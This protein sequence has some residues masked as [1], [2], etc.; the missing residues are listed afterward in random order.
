MACYSPLKA[1]KLVN[2]KTQSGKSVIVFSRKGLSHDAYVEMELPCGQCIGCRIDKSRQWAL[3]SVHEASLYGDNS[4]VTLTYSPENLPPNG[5]LTR[6]KGNDFQKFMKRLRKH[7]KGITAVTGDN[8]KV[9]YP[10]RFLQCGEYGDK[11]GR[12]HHHACIFNFGFPD[13]RLWNVVNGNRYYRSELL[14][15]LWPHGHSIVGLLSWQSAAYVGRYVTKKVL[16][17]AADNHYRRVDKE[18]GEVYYL[19]PE[20]CTMSNRPGIGHGWVQKYGNSDLYSKDYV[21]YDGKKFRPPAYYDTVFERLG[22]KEKQELCEIKRKRQVKAGQK[23]PETLARLK[24][25]RRCQELKARKLV[26]TME[27]EAEPVHDS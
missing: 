19:E 23:I 16:G 17:K 5:S 10:I 27:D 12:P 2:R 18:T 4:F 7:E 13:K 14:E 9:K 6:G 21:T 22:K 25:E 20:Y 11:L 8:G 1:Y 24:V 15:K 3:R 26:R